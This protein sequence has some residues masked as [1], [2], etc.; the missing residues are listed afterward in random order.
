MV[1]MIDVGAKDAVPRSAT[2][3]GA[4]RLLPATLE[5]IAAG[6]VEKGDV[7]ATAKLAAIQ[8]AKR[9]PDLIP[10]CHP[11]RLD[12]VK[13]EVTL[14]E[15]RLVLR[16]TVTAHERTG[17]EMEALTAVSL[18]L[19]TVWDMVKGI[20]KDAV[21]QYPHTQILEL[22]VEEKRVERTPS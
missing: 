1:E 20:E 17:V 19:L 12:A 21:G 7:V 15:D 4:I 6:K 14:E 3:V 9:T 13:P 10:L 22:R 2:A 16:C 5:A 18:G 11:L 8:G